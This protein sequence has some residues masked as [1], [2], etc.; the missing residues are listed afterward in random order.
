MRISHVLIE[1]FHFG[2]MV[3]FWVLS[4][5]GVKFLF[6]Y[7]RERERTHLCGKGQ[8][9]KERDNLRQNPH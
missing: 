3:V 8:K 1:A 9:G 4:G 7:L 6:I 2:P 5:G